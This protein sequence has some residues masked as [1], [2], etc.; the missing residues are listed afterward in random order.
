MERLKPLAKIFYGLGIAGIGLLEFI[1][2][3]FRPVVLPIPPETT[4]HLNILVYL[5]S[6]VLVISGGLIAFGKNVKA[7]SLF[8]GTFFMLFF[9]LG[10]LPN[11][12]ANSPGIPGAWTDALKLLALAG[13]ALIISTLYPDKKSAGLIGFIQK[14]APYGK[15]FFALLLV[16]FGIDHFLYVDFVKT[17]VPTWIPGDLIWTYLA[18]LAL[19][20]AGLAIF[21][22]FK[23]GMISLLLAA[24]LF[25]WLIVL[26]IP[27]GFAAPATDDGNEW[28]SVFECLAFSGMAILYP[29]SKKSIH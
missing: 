26:H 16:V 10:H 15:Y 19:I 27:R 21:I 24:M 23:P 22:N 13:G 6:A 7:S 12:I 25:I 8:L 2:P 4:A 28:T 9:I 3:G 11:R 20:G 14:I 29:Y 5:T 17:L 18:A 1:Y